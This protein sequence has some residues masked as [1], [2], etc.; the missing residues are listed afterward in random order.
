MNLEYISLVNLIMNKKV[1]TE[2]IQ[3]DFNK[4]TLKKEL[5]NILDPYERA[6]LYLDYYDLEK[7]LGGKGASEKTAK[8][9][10]NSIKN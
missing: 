7:K 4:N 2:L 5:D 6:K 10:Y 3:N 8:L 1:V 9:I